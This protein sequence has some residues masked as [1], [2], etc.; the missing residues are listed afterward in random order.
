MINHK[1]SF[2]PALQVF[3][4]LCELA[5]NIDFGRALSELEDTYNLGSIDRKSLI[6]AYYALYPE[7]LQTVIDKAHPPLY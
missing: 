3:N 1:N 6:S 7:K 2:T 4:E 5:E